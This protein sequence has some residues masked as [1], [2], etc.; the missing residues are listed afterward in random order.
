MKYLSKEK[1]KK[2]TGWIWILAVVILVAV[3]GAAVLFLNGGNQQQ[4]DPTP[5]ETSDLWTEPPAEE[6][7][8][9]AMETPHMTFTYPREW[10]GKVEAVQSTEGRNSTVTFQTEISGR[11]VVLFSVI[12]GPDAAE[13]YLLG[14]LDDGGNGV[15]NVYSVVNEVNPEEWTEE[16]YNEICALQERVNDIIVQFQEDERFSSGK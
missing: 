5:S 15:I 4:D 3:I 1:K 8:G 7:S 9:I 11:E 10:E 16:E 2:Q 6:P 12:L 13:G 14:Q